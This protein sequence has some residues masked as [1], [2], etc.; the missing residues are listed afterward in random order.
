MSRKR[1]SIRRQSDGNN[2]QEP[3]LINISANPKFEQGRMTMETFVHS[4]E[5]NDDKG[6]KNIKDGGSENN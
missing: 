6:L 4:M 5:F 1:A 3:T 2:Q